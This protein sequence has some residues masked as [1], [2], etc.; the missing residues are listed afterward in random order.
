MKRSS[1][2]YWEM[3]KSELARATREFDREYVA[4]QARPM[5]RAERAEE[6]RARLR[7]RPK[8]GLGSQK[9]HITVE[10]R[11]LKETD[12]L[13]KQRGLA[14]SELIAEAL[15]AMISRKAG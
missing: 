13:A 3:N 5:T 14:R 12:K 2:P 7:G 1:K 9:I 6:S 10:R 4:D 15:A 8:V 11:L